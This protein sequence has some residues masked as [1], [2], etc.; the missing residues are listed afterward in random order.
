VRGFTQTYYCADAKC[1]G[2]EGFEVKWAGSTQIDPAYPIDD[3]C[4]TCGAGMLDQP[5]AYED[6]ID[7]LMDELLQGGAIG[8]YDLATLDRRA[9]LAVVQ[10]ELTRQRLERLYVTV[11]C[12][13]CSGDGHYQAPNSVWE[14]GTLDLTCEACNGAGVVRARRQENAA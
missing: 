1:P 12:R 11:T 10:T 5:V 13:D 2:F 4:P 6:A 3:T 8:D 7:G 9:L 14:E